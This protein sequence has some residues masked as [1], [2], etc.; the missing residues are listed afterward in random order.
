MIGDSKEADIIGA[1]NVG[2]NA[3]HFNSHNEPLHELCIIVK[4]LKEIKFFL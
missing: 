1:L 2:I 3:I 4:S